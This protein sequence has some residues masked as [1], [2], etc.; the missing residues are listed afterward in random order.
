MAEKDWF[1]SL[2]KRYNKLSIRKSEA[3]SKATSFNRTNVEFFNK[4]LENIMSRYHF[5][6]QTLKYME[7]GCC[8][9]KLQTNR[10]RCC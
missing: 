9:E 3:T 5:H 4:N 2:T 10:K 7:Y 8:S 6:Y 1:T